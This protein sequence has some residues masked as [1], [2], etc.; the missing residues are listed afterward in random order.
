[1]STSDLVAFTS[2]TAIEQAADP[3]AFVVLA[4]ERAKAWLTQAIEQGDLESLVEIKSQAEAI[5][6]YTTQKQLGIDAQ[7]A[8]QEIV[9]RAER[10]IGLAIRAGQQAGEI[11]RRA[12]HIDGNG[13]PISNELVRPTDFATAA[14]L[15]SDGAGIYA[16]TDNV[17]DDQFE[18]AMTAAKDERNLSRANVVRKITESSER[19]AGL[20]RDRTRGSRARRAEV[21]RE[22]A[23]QAHNVAQICAA[24]GIGEE[25]V[26]E[27]ARTEGIEIPAEE[28]RRGT[29]RIDPNRVVETTV[30]TLEGVASSLDLIWEDFAQLDLSQ[31]EW[32]VTSLSSS[33]RALHRLNKQ[34]KEMTHG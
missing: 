24:T 30:T 20:A 2:T 12:R 10:G 4:C 11:S 27:I 9:R 8:A 21:I 13:H 32:W 25:L 1:M 7:L 14:E 31:A 23:A 26:R 15:S 33:L 29:R 17:S 28:L 22:M 16:I 19:V 18:E 34:L 3:A 6:I 5:R